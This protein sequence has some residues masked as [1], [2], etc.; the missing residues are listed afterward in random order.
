M[1][2]SGGNLS[3]TCKN[4]GGDVYLIGISY[5]K[6][7]KDKKHYCKIEKDFVKE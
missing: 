1:K 2:K 4:Y 3:G 6:E 5:D 7:S